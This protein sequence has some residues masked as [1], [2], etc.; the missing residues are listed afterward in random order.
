MFELNNLV[1]KYDANKI[2]LLP[3]PLILI[4]TE[5]P[6]IGKIEIQLY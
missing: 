4:A 5:F 6:L 1:F 3:F 2:T